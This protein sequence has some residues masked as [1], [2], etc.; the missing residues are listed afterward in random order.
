MQD[1]KKAA[2]IIVGTIA[3]M[4][5]LYLFLMIFLKSSG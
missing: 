4:L 1:E 3:V 5:V 2:G